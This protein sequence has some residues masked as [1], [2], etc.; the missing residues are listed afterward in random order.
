M[1]KQMMVEEIRNVVLFLHDLV[2]KGWIDDKGVARYTVA[3]AKRLR[4]V[5][6]AINGREL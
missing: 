3:Y 6:I 4:K 2:D 1:K 5:G